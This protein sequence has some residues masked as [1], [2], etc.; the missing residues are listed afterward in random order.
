MCNLKIATT[1]SA[2]LFSLA[3]NAFASIEIPKA[4]E[5]TTT[6]PA[7][8]RNAAATTVAR[9]IQGGRPVN[10]PRLMGKLDFSRLP[11]GPD[12]QRI[13]GTVNGVPISEKRFMAALKS[14]TGPQNPATGQGMQSALAEPTIHRLALQILYQDFARKNSLRISDVEVQHEVKNRNSAMPPGRKLQDT[15][16]ASGLS[17]D[18]MLENVRQELLQRRVEQFVGD[19]LTSGTPTQNEID[20]FLNRKGVKI[21]TG[22]E[23]MRVRHIVFRA[24]SDMSPESLED[25]KARAEFVLQKIKD[26][27]DFSEAARGHSQDR[28]TAAR[29]GDLGYVGRGSMFREFEEVAF[30][31]KPGE[32]S[33]LVRTPVGYHIV[34]VVEKYIGNAHILY[35]K[36]LREEGIALWRENLVKSARIE[37]FL[38]PLQEP[39]KF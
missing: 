24:T 21:S 39:K 2:L 19:R 13:V 37:N 22:T 26:G 5:S 29:G 18:E 1:L 36:D 11:K 6:K 16:A 28:F 23:E 14:H 8:S 32:I 15:A 12:G 17:M 33:G 34:Q 25:A 31:L 10:D 20:S 7:L 30:S 4:G 38:V 35:M 3:C 27:L 9:S